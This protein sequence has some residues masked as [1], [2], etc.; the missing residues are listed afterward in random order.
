MDFSRVELS[1]ED[2]RFRDELRAFLAEIVT[3]R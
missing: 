3:E 2:T 1:D